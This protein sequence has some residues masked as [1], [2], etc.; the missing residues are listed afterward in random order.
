M[1]LKKRYV[2]QFKA[3][4]QGIRDVLSKLEVSISRKAE[5]ASVFHQA[6]NRIEQFVG[7]G[8]EVVITDLK[9]V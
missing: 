5:R 1:D 3:S 2:V 9:E 8:Y 7:P 4:A 6:K